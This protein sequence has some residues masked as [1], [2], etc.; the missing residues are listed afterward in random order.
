M[1]RWLAKP[2]AV[3]SVFNLI[4]LAWMVDF[5]AQPKACFSSPAVAGLYWQDQFVA[6]CSFE[7]LWAPKV[8][9]KPE[10]LSRIAKRI[11]TLTAWLTRFG[12]FK[13]KPS[14]VVGDGIQTIREVREDQILLGLPVLRAEGQLERAWIE[15]WA[16]QNLSVTRMQDAVSKE[17]MVD[18]LLTLYQGG[19][20]L[21][22]PSTGRYEV[23][24]NGPATQWIVP[25]SALT[26]QARIGN[27]GGGEGIVLLKPILRQRFMTWFEALKPARKAKMEFLLIHFWKT[28]SWPD[29]LPTRL[30]ASA[31]DKHS[32]FELTF[33][34]SS[35]LG[36]LD[37][38]GWE[39]TV[40]SMWMALV[41]SRG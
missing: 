26:A 25:K 20:R 14:I 4:F 3:L 15:S 1:F 18:I 32:L 38:D 37:S 19:L 5:W 41:G 30:S 24:N 16:H 36:I 12:P 9:A 29:D 21:Q 40:N 33:G 13:V 8:A 6:T 17:V 28:T 22:D 11:D 10:E 35:T 7:Y 39:Q 34:V 27:I 31:A 23:I 2:S